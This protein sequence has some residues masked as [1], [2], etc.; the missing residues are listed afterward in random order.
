MVGDARRSGHSLAE[1]IVAV[2]FLGTSAAAVGSLAVVGAR[3]TAEAV[4]RQAAVRVAEAVLDSLATAPLVA[5]GAAVR[6]GH[7]VRWGPEGAAGI[8]VTVDRSA[9][10]PPVTLRGR[11]V[12]AVP[13]LPDAV[14]DSVVRHVTGSVP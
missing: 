2:V 1:L 7:R 9:G 8:R 3:R 4:D 10:Q 13:V 12:P 5:A 14:S 6:G 11:V